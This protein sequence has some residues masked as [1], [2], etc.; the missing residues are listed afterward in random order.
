MAKVI[1][2]DPAI[3]KD[4]AE[5]KKQQHRELSHKKNTAHLHFSKEE[6]RIGTRVLTK[7]ERHILSDSSHYIGARVS[8]LRPFLGHV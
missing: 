7:L 5:L 3:A 1:G 4:Q 6:T 2:F 8:N